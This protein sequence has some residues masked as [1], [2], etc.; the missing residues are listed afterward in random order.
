MLISS[1]LIARTLVREDSGSGFENGLHGTSALLGKE[2]K[3]TQIRKQTQ[4]FHSTVI[5]CIIYINSPCNSC[6]SICV[7]FTCTRIIWMFIFTSI[8]FIVK[9]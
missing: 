6:N 5:I 4:T 2:K 1:Y 9:H 3:H 8:Y 7:A